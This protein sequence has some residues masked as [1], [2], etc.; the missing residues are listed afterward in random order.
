[1]SYFD[2]LIDKNNTE[3]EAG[4]EY[5]YLFDMVWKPNDLESYPIKYGTIVH[6][7]VRLENN[8]FQFKI[9]NDEQIYCTNYGWSLAVNTDE[10]LKA[11]EKYEISK[12]QSLKQLKAI[13]NDLRS[14]I[15][16]LL[17]NK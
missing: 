10:N 11:I 14:N 17:N 9:G 7:V 13:T 4:K 6:S 12:K 2:F 1:M 15:I 5:V 3:P 16:T 8:S